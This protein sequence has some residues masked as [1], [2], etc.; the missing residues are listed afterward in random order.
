YDRLGN[1]L[2]QSSDITHLEKGF[3]VTDLGTMA[4]GGAA[5][6]TNRLGR[7][8]HDPPGPHPP[9]SPTPLSTH[10]P[11][12]RAYPSDANGN[13]TEIDGLRYTWDFLN[14]LV[15]VEDETMQADYRYDFTGRRIIKR[16]TP[17]SPP[18]TTRASAIFD[19]GKHFE[20]RERD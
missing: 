8:P 9:T 12:P 6:R 18:P 2:A 10:T 7:P 16:V 17:R 20:V 13:N 19:P 3:S 14:R 5:G 4:Y 1:M 11:P 15:A